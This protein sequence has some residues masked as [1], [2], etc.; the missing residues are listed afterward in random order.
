MAGSWLGLS[1][2]LASGCRHLLGHDQPHLS[3]QATRNL[4]NSSPR[5]R[6]FCP[7][8]PYGHEI[9]G[10]QDVAKV[11]AAVDQNCRLTEISSPNV[12]AHCPHNRHDFAA[13]GA[14]CEKEV[15]ARISRG[16]IRN[17]S[18]LA[19]LLIHYINGCQYGSNRSDR[20]KPPGSLARLH[21]FE[22]Q[23][24]ENPSSKVNPP[25][26]VILQGTREILG[27]Q[28]AN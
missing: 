7:H 14:G 21:A 27:A 11:G 4:A 3:E 24:P 13:S 17:L 1:L 2:V 6:F 8:L 12:S 15:G 20:L 19:M 25:N 16:G 26:I 9:C 22:N 18:C 28:I 23:G 5:S 10:V